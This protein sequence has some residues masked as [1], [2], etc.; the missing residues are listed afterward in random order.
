MVKNFKV[1]IDK[2][3]LE[4]QEAIAEKAFDVM[5]D[6][7]LDE[8]LGVFTDFLNVDV[9]VDQSEFLNNNNLS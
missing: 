2:M 6:M 3:S 9:F 1:L 8:L 7:P 4:S 5:D